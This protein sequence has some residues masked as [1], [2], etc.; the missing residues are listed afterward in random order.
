MLP[1]EE[2]DKRGFAFPQMLIAWASIDGLGEPDANLEAALACLQ[3][4]LDSDS[5]R[6]GFRLVH[7]LLLPLRVAMALASNTNLLVLYLPSQNQSLST[8]G[9]AI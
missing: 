5:N 8:K 7:S 9:L 4:K 3:M 6:V 1:I 2:S